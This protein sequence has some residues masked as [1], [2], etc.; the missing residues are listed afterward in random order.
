MPPAHRQAVCWAPASVGNVGVGFDIL[1]HEL[2]V[3]G[4]RVTVTASPEPGVRLDGVS[5]LVTTLPDD[6][7]SNTA[8]AGLLSLCADLDLDFGFSVRV[9]KGIPMGSGMGGS[10]ASAVGAAVAANALLAREKID[11]SA[12]VAR[13][14]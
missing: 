14:L 5:G 7:A 2:T 8:T 6:P 10:A 4:D 12:V 11:K 3:A 1:G 13:R 9:E